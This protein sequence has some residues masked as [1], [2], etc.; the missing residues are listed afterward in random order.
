MYTAH[1]SGVKKEQQQ[2]QEE[3]KEAENRDRSLAPPIFTVAT[4]SQIAV[5]LLT[6]PSLVKLLPIL[7]ILWT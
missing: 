4:F 5:A 6:W 2:Q 1:H 7:R 3:E